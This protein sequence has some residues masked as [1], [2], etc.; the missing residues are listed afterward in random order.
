MRC[1]TSD[2]RDD[3]ISRAEVPEGAEVLPWPR[4]PWAPRG[5]AV[6]P[7]ATRVSRFWPAG[8]A[9][10]RIAR[11]RTKHLS[12]LRWLPPRGDLGPLAYRRAAPEREAEPAEWSGPA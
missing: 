11:I 4:D 8:A 2:N 3:D 5:A 12:C 9:R 1:E 7:I 6:W 10:A